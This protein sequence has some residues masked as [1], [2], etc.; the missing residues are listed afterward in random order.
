MTLTGGWTGMDIPK[1]LYTTMRFNFL[2]VDRY[3]FKKGWIYPESY[4]PYCMLRLIL[5]GSAVFTID[6]VKHR[7][8][9]NQVAY[10]PEGCML[11]CYSLDEEIEFISIRFVTTARLNGNDFLAE[12][13]HIT[14]VADVSETSIPVY[15][16]EVYQNAKSEKL[17]RMFH[18]RG[19]LELIIAG[20]VDLQESQ[21]NNTDEDEAELNMQD[22]TAYDN[23]SNLSV[24][25][26]QR[27]YVREKGAFKQDPRIQPVID[28]LVTNP[29]RKFD[30]QL[31]ADMANMSLSSFRRHFK[32]HT[33]KTPGEFHTD[34]KIMVA[35][36]RLLV[37]D[38]RI[39]DIAY[40][41]GFQSL[42]YFSRIFKSTF[43]VSPSSYRKSGRA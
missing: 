25:A 30:V 43:G 18:I 39:S 20:L 9:Q 38:E 35:A 5:A 29:E 34:L 26:M 13:F 15:F 40:E 28:Y 41:V 19:D 37:T 27:A 7:V 36:R 32:E 31:M 8:Q 10:I 21:A 3:L 11:E 17:S 14:P 16:D 33:G 24:Q 1:S 42:N 4:V 23:L 22:Q 2:Y 6:G 12:F